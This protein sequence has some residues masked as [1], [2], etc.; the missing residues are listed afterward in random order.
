MQPL[1]CG[2]ET[3]TLPSTAVAVTD[4]A[5]HVHACSRRFCVALLP[6]AAATSSATTTASMSTLFTTHKTDRARKW[7]RPTR[8]GP[9][10][11]RPAGAGLA[12]R[13]EGACQGIVVKKASLGSVARSTAI[14]K[15]G[16]KTLPLV[17]MP[18]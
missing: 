14:P 4:D 1:V 10:A 13:V 3:W 7:I 15:N 16:W 2:S 11:A 8:P 6:L 18:S 9:E 17:V 5:P 12:D